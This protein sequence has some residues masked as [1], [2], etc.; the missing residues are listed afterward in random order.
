MYPRLL[1]EQLRDAGHDVIAVVEQPDLVGRPT[2]DIARWA[3]EHQRV[4][5]TENVVGF[6][7]LD[8]DDHA[9]LLLL[10]ARRWPRTRAGLGRLRVRSRP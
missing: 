6:A 3:R 1:A 10:N 4:V 9:G 2:I 7:V 5:V 8:A